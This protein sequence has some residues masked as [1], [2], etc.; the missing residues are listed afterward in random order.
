MTTEL[1]TLQTQL[2]MA[3]TDNETLT[4]ENAK[5]HEEITSSRKQTQES[6]QFSDLLHQKCQRLEHDAVELGRQRDRFKA[7]FE[8]QQRLNE[9]L[10][11]RNQAMKLG[12]NEPLPLNA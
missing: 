5:L 6:A 11:K 3:L 7:S 1:E 12:K 2:A 10:M 8:T 4:A 9:S